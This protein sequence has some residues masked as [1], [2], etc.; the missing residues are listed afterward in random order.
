MID[1]LS[2]NVTIPIVSINQS[3]DEEVGH[4]F[5]NILDLGI[6]LLTK[7]SLHHPQERFV[8]MLKIWINAKKSVKYNEHFTWKNCGLNPWNLLW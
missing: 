6:I 7:T 2:D 1:R 3:L 4:S 8:E 5:V